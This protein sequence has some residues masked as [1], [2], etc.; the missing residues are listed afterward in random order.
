MRE[1]PSAKCPLCNSALSTA[2]VPLRVHAVEGPSNYDN[3]AFMEPEGS[4]W[5]QSANHI[6]PEVV[7]QM[8]HDLKR[9]RRKYDHERR[10]RENERA[11]SRACLESMQAEVAG[12]EAVKTELAAAHLSMERASGKLENEVIRTREVLLLA[13]RYIDRTLI[14]RRRNLYRLCSSRRKHHE[15]LNALKLA[16]QQDI[17]LVRDTAREEVQTTVSQMDSSLKALELVHQRN[18][19]KLAIGNEMARKRME[20]IIPEI[21][22]A[23]AVWV[24]EIKRLRTNVGDSPNDRQRLI[25]GTQNLLDKV[26]RRL[27]QVIDQI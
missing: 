16:H 4:S 13:Q 22:V 8:V 17:A 25:E 9:F 3:D 24:A 11:E 20:A 27:H 10:Q 12:V 6:D 26:V 1:K 21:E 2:L 5:N 7:E 14:W 23:K 18:I 19:F 15:K